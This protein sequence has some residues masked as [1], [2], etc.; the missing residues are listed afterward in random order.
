MLIKHN[1]IRLSTWL[2]GYDFEIGFCRQAKE[3][4]RLKRIL[5]S[6]DP[7]FLVKHF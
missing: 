4:V 2:E 7:A 5:G 6:N 3:M 1:I